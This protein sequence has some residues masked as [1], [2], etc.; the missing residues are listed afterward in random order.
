[1][2]KKF[3]YSEIN[4][5]M[6]YGAHFG[7]RIIQIDDDI[8]ENS[9]GKAMKALQ[10]MDQSS[11]ESIKIIINSFG[12]S[13]YDGLALYDLIRSCRCEVHTYGYGKI[14]SMST[15]LFLAGDKRI[16]SPR[17]TIMVHEISDS[18]HGQ[19]E[20]LSISL[21]EC[22]RLQDILI[23][24]YCERTNN[25]SKKHWA[26]IRKDKYIH[27]KEAVRMGFAHEIEEES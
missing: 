25:K 19:L 11:D 17:A 23:D 18:N 3:D 9:V 6:D 16:L 15:F 20:D 5:F 4:S 22:E 2:A 8:D 27:P 10:I 1:M 7:L 12:G 21:K 26:S 24:I 13:V 14:M